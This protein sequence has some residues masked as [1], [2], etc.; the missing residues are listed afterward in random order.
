[1]RASK[2]WML[3][4]LLALAA[5]G[6]AEDKAADKAVLPEGPK[7]E[8]SDVAAT[9]L[10]AGARAVALARIEGMVIAEVERKERD[11]MTFY[12]V[13]GAR[14]DGSEVELDILEKDGVFTVVE[15]QRDIAW[16]AA[17]APV[18]AAAEAAADHFAPARVIESTQNDGTVVYELFAPGKPTEPAAEVNWKDGKA[19]LRKERNAY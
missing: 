2:I 17:P 7:A 8:I 6:T 16:S 19:A 12:D 1:M 15:V 18:R 9:D 4:P 5:C 10:P 3:A 14:P 13:E 11:G